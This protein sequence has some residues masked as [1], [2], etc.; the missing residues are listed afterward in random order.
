[1]GLNFGSGCC[2]QV[3]G[4]LWDKMVNTQRALYVPQ[5]KHSNVT[6]LSLQIL[7]HCE[8]GYY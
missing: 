3:I 5:E 7:K 4:Y 2:G 8:S 6:E 1:M